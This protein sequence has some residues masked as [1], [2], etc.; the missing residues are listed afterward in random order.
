MQ[1]TTVFG[2]E[3]LF[4]IRNIFQQPRPLLNMLDYGLGHQWPWLDL[5]QTQ[6]RCPIEEIF[7][8]EAFYILISI[9]SE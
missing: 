9:G 4:N 7:S 5:T 2:N 3:G 1:R 8:L 6:K